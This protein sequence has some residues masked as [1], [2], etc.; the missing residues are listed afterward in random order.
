MDDTAE[1]EPWTPHGIN[2]PPGTRYFPNQAHS[3]SCFARMCSLTEVLNQ[4][5][6]LLYTP[7]RKSTEVEVSKLGTDLRLWWDDLPPYL[8]IV[9]SE[10]PAFSPP[11]HIVTLK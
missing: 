9:L 1:I 3:T 5:L 10:L 11:S 6:I 2:F 4:I 7:D 8:R